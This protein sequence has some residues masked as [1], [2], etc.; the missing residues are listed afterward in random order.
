MKENIIIALKNYISFHEREFNLIL[1]IYEYIGSYTGD[2]IIA[3]LKVK[4]YTLYFLMR[5]QFNFSLL[6]LNLLNLCNELAPCFE[7]GTIH[8]NI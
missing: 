7:F 1:G 2:V 8:L 4:I 6:I 3:F 5:M